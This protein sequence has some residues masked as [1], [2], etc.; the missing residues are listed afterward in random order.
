[1]PVRALSLLVAL[2]LALLLGAC[3]GSKPQATVSTRATTTDATTT[4]AMPGETV[5]VRAYFIRGG[6]LAAT[7][8]KDGSRIDGVWIP[9][10]ISG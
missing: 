8:R 10:L 3:G 6:K 4:D 1:M 5:F 2:A 9:L 7:G